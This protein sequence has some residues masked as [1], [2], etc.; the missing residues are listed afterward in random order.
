MIPEEIITKSTEAG[1][2]NHHPEAIIEVENTGDRSTQ[3]DS[4]FYFCEVNAVL[5]FKHEV[6][7]EKHLDIPV[8]AA[9]RSEPRDR[10]EVQLVEY[11]GERKTSGFRGMVNGPTNKSHVYRP[12]GENDEYA[13]VS[14]GDGTENADKKGGKRS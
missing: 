3:A 2:N 14:G 6:A 7:Y 10:K 5:N 12:T 11:A 1:V 13:G 4:H 9:V 8:R